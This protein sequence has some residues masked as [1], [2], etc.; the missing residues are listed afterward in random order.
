MIIIKLYSSWS[1]AFANL[2]L[3]CPGKLNLMEC[4]VCALHVYHTAS[5]HTVWDV[6]VILLEML[7]LQEKFYSCIYVTGSYNLGQNR[8]VTIK[9][10]L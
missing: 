10:C 4:A 3:V 5:Y 7:L 9:V 2:R 1:A 8:F 6:T